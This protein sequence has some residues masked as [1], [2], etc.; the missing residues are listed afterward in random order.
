MEIQRITN[1]F[2]NIKIINTNKTYMLV[3]KL[4]PSNMLIAFI[5]ARK[6]NI[7]KMYETFPNSILF[8]KK[9]TCK[10]VIK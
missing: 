4:I 9:D 5:N 8:S 6:Q 7:V 2:F 1:A 3:C 10:L